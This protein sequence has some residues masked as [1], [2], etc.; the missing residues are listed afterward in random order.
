MNKK[1]KIIVS[2]V[3]ITIVLL[4]LLGITYAYYLTRIQGNTNTNSISIT[5]ADLKLVYGDGTNE[6]LTSDTAL[7]PSTDLTDSGKIGVKDFSVT[8][9]G[10][11]TSYVVVIEN[12]SVTKAS[13]GTSTTFLSNDFR[14]TLTCKVGDTDTSCGNETKSLSIFPI[15]GGVVLNQTI[16]EGVVHNYEFKLWYIDTGIDQSDDMGKSLQARINIKDITAANPYSTGVTATDNINLAYNIINNAKKGNNGTT[17]VNE[18][19]RQIMTEPAGFDYIKPNDPTSFTSSISSATNYYIAYASDYS[20]NPVTGTFKLGTTEN[21]VTIMNSKYSYSSDLA[22]TLAGKYA[23]W[24]TSAITEETI[25]KLSSMYKI[26]PTASDI[27]SSTIKYAIMNSSSNSKVAGIGE[28]SV[29]ADDY[30]T[31]YYF[32]GNVTNN[33][34]TFASMCWRIVR[35]KGNGSIKLILEDQDNTCEEMSEMISTVENYNNDKGDF[36]IANKAYGYQENDNYQYFIDY[37]GYTGG[38][39]DEF[40][41][42]QT[43]LAKKIDPRIVVEEPEPTI[44][45]VKNTLASKLEVGDWCNTEG[46]KYDGD[47]QTILTEEQVNDKIT[48]YQPFY[49]DSYV[50]LE[51]RNPKEPTLKCNGTTM[52]KFRDNTDMY[53]GTL[54]ADEIAYA[55]GGKFENRYYYLMNDYVNFGGQNGNYIYW[56]SLSPGIFGGIYDY[57]FYVENDGYLRNIVVD[58][59]YSVLRPSVSLKSNTTIVLGGEGTMSNP[60]VIG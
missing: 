9:T 38:M 19:S 25:S 32:R 6:I 41:T 2:I 7:M 30:G 39:A 46:T 36:D 33:Y 16:D 18:S 60:Y 51:E 45:Q 55:G 12:V 43:T 21:P 13:D 57:A 31:S 8:N 42:Y 29:A 44:E 3:G 26:T 27:T 5:T 34:V 1:Q 48:N 37:L 35:I 20:V 56:W 47:Y 15:N 52:T 53:V 58:D 22:N 14:Y 50:R 4:A 54:T 28:L 24:S 11:A 59:G 17:L 23:Y 10:N 49:Y 40:Q